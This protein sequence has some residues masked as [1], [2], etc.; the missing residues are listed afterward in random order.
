MMQS[1]NI[2]S[3]K[4]YCVKIFEFYAYFCLKKLGVYFH[5]IKLYSTYKMKIGTKMSLPF[6]CQLVYKKW[7]M[8]GPHM[9][10]LPF[11][12]ISVSFF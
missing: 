8:G 4:D 12:L 11:I 10:T 2:C 1:E 6:T 9:I 7:R 3:F 5:I